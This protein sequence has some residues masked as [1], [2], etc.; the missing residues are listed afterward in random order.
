TVASMVPISLA[1]LGVREGI[2]IYLFTKIGTS[3]EEALSLSLL[4]FFATLIISIIG[5]IEYVRIG[6]KK[7]VQAPVDMDKDMEMT[8]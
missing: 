5:G 4:F 3:Q 7:A 1:G 2:F 8:D 6:G